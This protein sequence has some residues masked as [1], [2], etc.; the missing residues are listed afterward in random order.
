MSASP[1]SP[2]RA[3]RYGASLL[4]GLLSAGLA[5]GVGLVV[6]A[7]ATTAKAD[8]GSSVTVSARDQDADAANAPFPDLKLTV[9][10]TKGLV[11][12]AIVLSWT[13]GRK[14]IQPSQQNGGSDFLQFAQCWGDDPSVPAG[15]PAQ[16]D[17][18]T[19]QYGGFNSAGTTRDHYHA[20]G[21]AAPQDSAYTIAEPPLGDYTS[22]PFRA[23]DGT[24]STNIVDGVRTDAVDPNSNQFFTKY[25]T[26]EVSWAGSGDDGT[27]AVKFEVQTKVQAPGLGCG[28]AELQSDGSRI[29]RSCWLVAIPRGQADD[30]SRQ[31]DQSGLF[32]SQWKHRLAVKLD[33]RPVGD[34]CA[35]GAA[36]RQLQGS[37]LAAGAI[38]SWQPV[39]CG[40]AGGDA[41][42]VLTGTESD[43]AAIA[44]STNVGPMALTSR[45]LQ[46]DVDDQ[47]SYA[48]V[49]LTGVAVSFAIDRRPSLDGTVP[50]DVLAR[51]GL[52][53]ESMNLTPRL[54]AKLLT[55]SYLDALPANADRTHLGGNPRNLL[56]DPD[57]LAINDPEWKYQ[58]IVGPAVADALVPQGRSD[59]ASAL[60]SYVMA[61]AD[62]RAFLAGAKDP[63]GM[64][65]NKWSS[66]DPTVAPKSDEGQSYAQ[67]YP[68]DG[69][70]KAD[71]FEVVS[72]LGPKATVNSVTWRPYTNDLDSSAYKTL[73]GDGQVLGGWNPFATPA[74]YDKAVRDL[75]GS[76]HVIGVTDA[77]SAAKYLTVTAS[78]RNPAGQFVAPTT[79]GFQAAAAAMTTSSG[80]T[81]VYGFDPASPQAQSATTA[82]PLTMPVYAAVNPAM[83]DAT[84]RASYAVFIRY[85]A[86]DA[87]QTPG[88]DPGSLPDGYA[89][90][91]AGWRA[92]ALAAADRIQAGGLVP[93]D[94]V[95]GESA[96]GSDSISGS[97]GGGFGD[98]QLAASVSDD[99]AA[100]GE[101]AAALSASKTPADPDVDGVQA[102][103]PLSLLAGLLGALA[104]PAISRLR[105][106]L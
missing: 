26:N 12:Q 87:A 48:P 15:E 8:D 90:L 104:V 17:R 13:G 44:N 92:Q 37:E 65:V 21:S 41:Y 101:L 78:L 79:T 47:L 38:A 50:R 75:P 31:V 23:V 63:W 34:V 5:F 71:P 103:M 49:A 6:T 3:R 58:A 77:S 36:E 82:Y 68:T 43:A 56:Y 24:V 39:L 69:F 106:R 93:T 72:E 98:D 11:S 85:A 60:W 84:L 83:D 19:C 45:P 27:G 70:P 81:Q 20:S 89:P 96:G 73:R 10:Q 80:S 4:A 97:S 54:V 52:P 55:S 91:P 22:I 42:T 14:S 62:A 100:S 33:F 28:D 94:P 9:S 18:T 16:P 88:V 40:S 105:R 2:L 35:I 66:S 59:A 67:T 74:G 61:D 76:Q 29:G 30:G 64:T 46:G 7:P 102:V 99:P 53:F 57:F 25:T 32:W 86:S 51:A 1:S 95:T